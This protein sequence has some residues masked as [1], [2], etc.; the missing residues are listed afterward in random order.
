MER[1]TTGQRLLAR[2][3]NAA[4]AGAPGAMHRWA[5]FFAGV[6]VILAFAFGVLPA[7][8]RLGPVREVHDAI[9]ESGIDATALFYTESEMSS[10]AEASIRNA[11]RYPARRTDCAAECPRDEQ[12]RTSTR[13]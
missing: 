5:R 13:R 3:S 11:L 10:D 12:E 8:Q 6:L 1:T 4:D 2:S 7:V 9:Q